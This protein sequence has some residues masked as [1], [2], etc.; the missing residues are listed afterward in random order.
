[1]ITL[2]TDFGHT[3]SYVGVMKGVIASINPRCQVVDI[4]HGIRPQDILAARFGLLASY[5]YFPAGTIHVVVVDPGVGT[6]RM[7][8]AAQVTTSVG[9]HI[10][11]AP[12][13]GVFTG[14][15]ITRAVALQNASYWRTSQPSHTF[16]G[17]DIFAP[18]AAHLANGVY[19]EALGPAVSSANLV[20][21]RIGDAIA[22][23][24]GYRGSIQYIDHF[25]NLITTIPADSLTQPCWYVQLAERRLS[26]YITYG[27]AAADAA[28]ALIG[29]HGYV[30]IAVNGGSAAQRF[31]AQIGDP[32]ELTYAPRG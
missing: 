17:R 16:H 1:M 31:S 3:D 4:T 7:A 25:G 23:H 15:S 21:L 18:V 8:V 6:Q 13:N 11:V 26:C 24:H 12:D 10:I 32:V 29:S 22:T 5:G 9:D 19:L 20:Q 27:Q 30:E 2:L 14:F 28:L